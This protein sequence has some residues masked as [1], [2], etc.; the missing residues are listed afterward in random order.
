M[1]LKSKQITLL[2]LFN[3]I[4]KKKKQL[5]HLKIPKV[6]FLKKG[7]NS[8]NVLF[9]EFEKFDGYK[10]WWERD[11]KKKKS[12]LFLNFSASARSSGV[13][14]CNVFAVKLAG[15]CEE[16]KKQWIRGKQK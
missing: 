9:K 11:K 2:G 13:G 3:N 5:K 7:H 10:R 1:E 4:K 6:Y 12:P 16:K 14:S 8:W 15:F